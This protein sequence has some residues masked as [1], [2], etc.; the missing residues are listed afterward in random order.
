MNN[1]ISVISSLII[2]LFPYI[3]KRWFDR[4]ILASTVVSLG[5]LGTFGG[6]FWGL[7]EFDVN[8][9]EFAL[10]Q[11]LEGLKTAFLTSIAG[12]TSSLILKLSPILYGIRL[13]STSEHEQTETDQLLGLLTAIEKNTANMQPNS[14][15]QNLDG[16]RTDNAR[17]FAMLNENLQKITAHLEKL[18]QDIQQKDTTESNQ[19]LAT[20]LEHINTTIEDLQKTQT[21]NTEQI[22]SVLRELQSL[23]ESLGQT[24]GQLGTYLNKSV[25][26]SSHQ[27]EQITTQMNNLGEFVKTTE[28][29]FEQQLMNMEE[30]FTRELSAMEQFTKTL[31]SIIKKLS[32]DH[33]ALAQ[34]PRNN[35]PEV[36]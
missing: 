35:E 25:T 7:L 24:S 10:P 29:Q 14:S 20:V 21:E 13:E 23:L 26:M 17:N 4:N 30:K 22:S 1:T 2:L 8:S 18:S 34:H 6:I 28:T 27:Q 16:L 31:L 33:S 36:N 5:L 12:M 19:K 3:G 15:I 32:Q 9:V 11:L